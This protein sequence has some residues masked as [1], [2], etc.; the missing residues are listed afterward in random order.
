L[1]G[2]VFANFCRVDWHSCRAIV[3][4]AAKA[5]RCERQRSDSLRLIDIDWRRRVVRCFELNVT[6]SNE[7]GDKLEIG[8]ATRNIRIQSL[9]VANLSCVAQTDLESMLPIRTP[10]KPF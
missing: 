6:F 9:M 4:M 10:Q 7:E 8:R 3:E 1:H 2:V 5:A